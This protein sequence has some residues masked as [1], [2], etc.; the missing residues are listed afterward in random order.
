MRHTIAGVPID[1]LTFQEAAER[2]LEFLSDGR[3]HMI[4]TP[5]P[6]MAVLAARDP[7]FKKILHTSSLALADGYGLRLAAWWEGKRIP[8]MIT[9]VD[10]GLALVQIAEQKNCSV[11]FL[12]AGEGVAE[13]AARNL[14]QVYKGLRIAGAS[15]D[16]IRWIAGKWEEESGLVARIAATKPEILFV[17]LGHGKQERWIKDHLP[18]LPTVRIAIG[19][20]GALDYYS[21]QKKRAPSFF[22]AL[23]LEWLWRLLTEPWRAWRIFEAVFVFL[24]MVLKNPRKKVQ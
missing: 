3:Q 7:G 21:G 6:E 19:V 2:A 23:H 18:H 24:A 5:N 16:R 15:G 8:T 9:G 22:R 17:A 14:Q 1:A 4:V 13:K 10:F 20:G 12:G 11:Y